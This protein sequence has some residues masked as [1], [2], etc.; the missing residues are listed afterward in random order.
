MNGTSFPNRSFSAAYS[1][2]QNFQESVLL[3]D[4]VE[5]GHRGLYLARECAK[6]R[7]LRIHPGGCFLFLKN[8]SPLYQRFLQVTTWTLATFAGLP[9]VVSDGHLYPQPKNRAVLSPVVAPGR[10]S[11]SH[12]VSIDAQYRP[13][14]VIHRMAWGNVHGLEQST[15]SLHSAGCY[16][17]CTCL[18]TMVH[19][20]SVLHGCSCGNTLHIFVTVRFFGSTVQPRMKRRTTTHSIVP[21]KPPPRPSTFRLPLLSTRL[22][23]FRWRPIAHAYNRAST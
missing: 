2:K 6:K 15:E 5:G 10:Q 22:S 12:G 18:L 19:A 11:C 13:S 14:V 1:C 7:R 16:I 17:R 23:A 21:K 8:V 3:V 9:L 4:T 20:S